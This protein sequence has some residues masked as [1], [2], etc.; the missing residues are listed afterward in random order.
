MHKVGKKGKKGKKDKKAPAPPKGKAPFVYV[1]PSEVLQC[2]CVVQYAEH[3]S[4]VQYSAVQ[5]SAA[6]CSVVQRSAVQHGMEF[7][8]EP[9]VL[10]LHS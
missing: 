1:T 7:F 5:C 9:R 10:I 8:I 3:C 6:Q 2:G 4:V